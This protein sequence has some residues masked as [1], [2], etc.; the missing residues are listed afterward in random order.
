LATRGT[1]APLR[2]TVDGNL[3]EGREAAEEGIPRTLE[4][5]RLQWF[6]IA[7]S[8]RI[9]NTNSLELSS[10]FP[11]NKKVKTY[12]LKLA[13]MEC[14]NDGSCILKEHLPD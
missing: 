2:C 4:V 1:K 3:D 12:W 14:L 5:Q 7:F 10:A 9:C 13:C 6:N 8:D 11:G